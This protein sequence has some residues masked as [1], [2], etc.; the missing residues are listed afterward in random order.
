[1]AGGNWT[2]QNKVRPG[3]YINFKSEK[4]G[5]NISGE[6]GIVTL[7]LILPFGPEKK[8]LEVN[9]GTNIFDVVGIDINDSSALLIREALKRANK[10]LLYRLN[11]GERAK[12]THENLTIEAKYSGTKGNN[13]KIIIQTNIVDNTAFDVITM[14][15]NMQIDKQSAVKTIADLKANQFVTF[16]GT[17]TLAATAGINLTGGTDGTITNQNYTEYFEAI[18][19]YEFNTMGIATTDSSLKAVAVN[20]VKRLREQEG[21][22]IQVVLE[23]YP[24]ADYEGVISVKNGVILSD[25]TIITSDKA[26]AFVAGATAGADINQSNTYV[27]YEGAMDVDTRYTN[28]EIESALK[29]GEIVF[30]INNGKVVIEQ[31]INTLKTFTEERNKDFR[32]NRVLR[33]LDGINKEIKWLWD[34]RY[35]G[36]GH[37]NEDGRNLFKK[38]IIKLLESMQAV[39]A[40][41]NVVAED[42][43][44]LSGIDK[45]SVFVQIA[46]Q[47]VDSM[48]KLYME[49]EVR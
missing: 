11:S 5:E 43:G 15:G 35:V 24:E 19:L 44:I 25:N 10:V 14:A 3:A 46:A 34:T 4:K 28:A 16:S 49:V 22:K 23:K 45:D 26:V 31:D 33:V 7:P 6:R 17:G 48:E 29:N 8:V 36:K 2:K 37:N 38:D 21:R 27:S 1:M 32:K 30:T 9:T 47:P 20:F 42:V 18:E 12:A 39:N 41:Q 13:V 40:L